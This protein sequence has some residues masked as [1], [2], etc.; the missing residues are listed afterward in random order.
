MASVKHTASFEIG[1]SIQDTFPLF[2]AEGEKLWVP[3]WE[4]ENVM[5]STDLREDYV[6]V[7]KSHDHAAA[8]A[9]WV[10]KKHEPE[11][12][13][14]QFYRVEPSEKVGIIEVKCFS[15]SDFKTK[16]RV[17]YEYVGLSA[18]GNEFIL[19]FSPSRYEAFISEWR[20]LLQNYFAEK[21]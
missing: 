5:G 4:Y 7:T 2:S 10:V 18:S 1:Q 12:Y 15:E 17:T 3:G 13:L 16:V 8:D 20:T 11:K 21:G 19:E 6:F 9:I 14:V